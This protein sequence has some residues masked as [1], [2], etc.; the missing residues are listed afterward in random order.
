MEL[1]K[2]DGVRSRS[3][4][5]SIGT[6]LYRQATPSSQ[7]EDEDSPSERER[8]DEDGNE[9]GSAPDSD[10]DDDMDISLREFMGM[11]D[12]VP[13][14]PTG[15]SRSSAAQSLYASS[16]ALEPADPEDMIP[17]LDLD[18]S[19]VAS[20]MSIRHDDVDEAME[21]DTAADK[22]SEMAIDPVTPPQDPPLDTPVSIIS[23]G[24]EH[25]HTEESSGTRVQFSPPQLATAFVERSPSEEYNEV[26]FMSQSAKTPSA[27]TVNGARPVETQETD[28]T[29][30]RQASPAHAHFEDE[31]EQRDD[32]VEEIADPDREDASQA[33]G[34][35]SD[36]DEEEFIPEYLKPYAIAP[37]Q[38]E[39]QAKV[40][41]PLLLRGCLR[42]YQQAGLEWLASIHMN[43]LNGILADEMGLG[44]GFIYN[45]VFAWADNRC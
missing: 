24:K 12:H 33:D 41:A 28:V 37:V 18:G 27:V 40:K 45:M 38:W 25:A 10:D 21:V 35:L 32:D 42:P 16:P 11:P 8:E 31:N 13:S 29:E 20:S 5:S 17:G 7:H 22:S 39:P 4:S 19:S 3:R 6:T 14:A 36:E 44:F 43:N 34:H 15:S 23:K 1:S 9:D 30:S 2:V 26:D